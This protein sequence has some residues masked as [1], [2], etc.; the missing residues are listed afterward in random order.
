MS[1]TPVHVTLVRHGRSRADDEEVHEGRYDSPLT[2][3]EQAQARARAAHFL[4]TGQRFDR[5]ISSPLQRATST[6]QITADT[7]E[8]PLELDRDARSD[9]CNC[10]P[11]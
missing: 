4:H 5:V 9:A 3:I 7:L 1:T 10:V 11:G 2:A 8:V 6:A